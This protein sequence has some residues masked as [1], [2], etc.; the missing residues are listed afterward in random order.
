MVALSCS[1]HSSQSVAVLPGSLGTWAA[2][3]R[4]SPPCLMACL[5]RKRERLAATTRYETKPTRRTHRGHAALCVEP[6]KRFPFARPNF[7]S[8]LRVTIAT[9]KSE[10]YLVMCLR[11][12]T[13]RRTSAFVAETVGLQPWTSRA[14]RFA[15]G[16]GLSSPS[17]ASPVSVPHRAQHCNLPSAQSRTAAHAP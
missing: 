11:H 14:S 7:N 9:T 2:R 5:V 6:D 15:S 1:E 13:S 16:R 12:V 17:S 4:V 8:I 10:E 3:R